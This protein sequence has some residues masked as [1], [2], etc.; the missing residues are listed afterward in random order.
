MGRNGNR[1]RQLQSEFN[2]THKSQ[3][4]EDSVAGASR[5]RTVIFDDHDGVS[6]RTTINTSLT[7]PTFDPT[8]LKLPLLAPPSIHLN[9]SLES[10]VEA[11][12][13]EHQKDSN[14]NT[15]VGDL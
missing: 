4:H 14:D 15:Q 10:L 9:T 6:M 13:E 11:D 1:K 5:L 7:P 12:S 2:A 3:K 8:V